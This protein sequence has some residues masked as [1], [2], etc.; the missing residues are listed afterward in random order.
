[1]VPEQRLA[2]GPSLGIFFGTPERPD[3][4]IIALQALVVGQE[5]FQQGQG[6]PSAVAIEIAAVREERPEVGAPQGCAGLSVLF[7]QVGIEEEQ[8]SRAPT[9]QRVGIEAAVF[10]DRPEIEIAFQRRSVGAGGKGA[11]TRSGF[12]FA[13]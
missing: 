7:D 9:L 11:G 1:E 10:I 3:G 8:Q 5:W 2:G 6:L 13:E 4:R 12:V